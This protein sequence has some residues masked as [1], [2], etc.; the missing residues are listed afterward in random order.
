MTD[1]EILKRFGS[2][3]RSIRERRGFSAEQVGEM[4]SLSADAVRKYER[5]KRELGIIRIVR[6]KERLNVD[7]M[8]ML[9]GLEEQESENLEYN[10]LS[11]RAKSILRQLATKWNGDIEA[12]IIIMGLL[13]SFP[14]K[15]RR[16]IYMEIDKKRA[17]LLS[18]GVLQEDNLPPG[19]DYMQKQ[20]GGLYDK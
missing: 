7:Y 12:L 4:M 5:G 16:E 10:I 1:D 9:A 13:A 15:S 11:P 6:A 3:L 8:T 19:L 17:D 2:K 14:E 20:L 18:N